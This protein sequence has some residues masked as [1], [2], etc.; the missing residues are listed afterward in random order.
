MQ[1]VQTGK[2]SNQSPDSST[3]SCGCRLLRRSDSYLPSWGFHHYQRILLCSCGSWW[4]NQANHRRLLPYGNHKVVAV[5]LAAS[6][7]INLGN[8]TTMMHTCMFSLFW[9]HPLASVSLYPVAADGRKF[10]HVFSS[11]PGDN[12]RCSVTVSVI[13]ESFPSTKHKPQKHKSDANPPW[14]HFVR[15]LAGK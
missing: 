10:K 13:V 14:V 6:P 9:P 4:A 8:A 15:L 11:W 12:S 2:P 7:Q 3:S 5:G 1:T